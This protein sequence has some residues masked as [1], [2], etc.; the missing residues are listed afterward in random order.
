MNLPDFA[1]K[2]V[3]DLY[4]VHK[5]L[6]LGS[7]D[8]RRLLCKMIVEQTTFDDPQGGWGHKAEKGG[9]PSKDTMGNF[10]NGLIAWD[11][12]NGST[13]APNPSP[14]QSF[15]LIPSSQEV[16]PLNGVDH[17]MHSTGGGGS[18]GGDDSGIDALEDRVEALER[19]VK[20]LSEQVSFLTATMLMDG[21]KVALQTDNGKYI[22]AEGGG[23]KKADQ[24]PLATDRTQANAWETYTIHK[25]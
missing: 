20:A 13:R 9:P 17:L 10:K 8:E 11:L 6:A 12:F 1:Y 21:S 25:K 14:I 7:D 5:N 22:T 24:Q 16:R 4:N 3:V 19:E 2:N 15:N 18:D 23:G